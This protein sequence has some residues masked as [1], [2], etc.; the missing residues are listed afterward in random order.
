MAS[1]LWRFHEV[2]LDEE[3]NQNKDITSSSRIIPETDRECVGALNRQF[4]RFQNLDIEDE[5]Q[6]YS[7]HNALEK[8]LE[9]PEAET[10][11]EAKFFRAQAAK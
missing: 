5:R 6:G 7:L 10:D 2:P 9:E 11:L 8:S 3:V 1:T 4:C